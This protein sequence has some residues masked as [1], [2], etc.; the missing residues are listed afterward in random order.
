MSKLLTKEE[1]VD[2]FAKV[3]KGDVR[4]RDRVVESV[5][6]FIWQQARRYVKRCQSFEAE[7]LVSEGVLGCLRAIES[8]EPERGLMFLTYAGNWIRQHMQRAIQ[9]QDPMVR[10]NPGLQ[11]LVS[12][13]RLLKEWETLRRKGLPLDEIRRQVGAKWKTS[14][15][16]IA[17]CEPLMFRRGPAYLDAPIAE[18]SDGSV[19]TLMDSR[20]SSAPRQDD[21]VERAEVCARVRAAIAEQPW[22]PMER[23]IIEKRLMGEARLIDLGEEFDRTRERIRQIE[24]KVHRKLRAR[25]ARIDAAGGISIR[26]ADVYAPHVE[27]IEEIKMEPKKEELTEKQKA[28]LA[29]YRKTVAEHGAPPSNLNIAKATALFGGKVE[30]QCV[31]ISRVLTHLR[32]LGLIPPREKASEK[33][34][35][36]PSPVRKIFKPRTQT[37]K[38]KPRA[39]KL[40]LRKLGED[41]VV[42]ILQA[43]RDELLE[44]A[45]VIDRALAALGA[46]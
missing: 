2:L 9:V 11:M 16:T 7:D 6:P 10:A 26:K 12:S 8:Y 40:K 3:R 28:V 44:K 33:K 32:N 21:E 37:A 4:A 14:P 41:P 1:Q 15:E 29:F 22:K 13:G 42:S 23:A 18:L 43:R 35:A 38:R 39:P 17:A 36:A 31:E 20:A 27:R 19:V 25:F 24:V 30:S 34:A 45:A 46:A 5:M